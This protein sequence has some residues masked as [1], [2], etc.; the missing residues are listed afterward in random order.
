MPKLAD[1]W[2]LGNLGHLEP[3]SPLARLFSRLK[4]L[5]RIL[6]ILHIRVE[7]SAHLPGEDGGQVLYGGESLELRGGT[8]GPPATTGQ[9]R[10]EAS[11]FVFN[12]AGDDYDA[13]FE[14]ADEPNLI[15]L[16]ASTNRVGYGTATPATRSHVSSAADDATSSQVR[17]TNTNAT[18]VNAAAVLAAFSDAVSTQL[19]SW[20]TANTTSRWGLTLGAWSELLSNSGNGLV[21]GVVNDKPLV[22][23][24]N[25]TIRFRLD[26]SG[27]VGINTSSYGTSAA[28]VISVASG[29]APTSS[30]PDVAQLWVADTSP[31]SANF[32]ARNE[33]GSIQQLTGLAARA[34][35]A[36]SKTSDTT[37]AD[38]S[39]LTRFVEASRTYAFVATLYTTSDAAGG[40]KAAIAGTATATSVIYEAM[41]WNA[42]AVAAQTRAT[43][44]GTAVG[45]VTAVTAALIVIRGTIT[46]NAGG[47]LLPQFSQNAS[48]GVA[49]TVLAGSTFE[50]TPI[51]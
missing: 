32:Y 18:G 19:S 35:S 48:S 10:I 37:L 20:C 13:R 7:N 26:A 39:D 16:D 11:A 12:E 21:I 14:G 15:F 6:A 29:T 34:T 33:S 5:E 46:V 31:G 27:N 50:L 1:I 45:G 22:F 51:A 2:R 17:A 49:S 41:V 36:F 23:G 38:V 44:L 28:K 8:P 3:Q 47:S 4:D 43:A 25:G 24:Q 42:A 9:V 30:P 40:V